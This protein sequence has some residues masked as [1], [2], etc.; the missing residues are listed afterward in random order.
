MWFLLIIGASVWLAIDE[1][2]TGGRVF[3]LAVACVSATLWAIS[4]RMNIQQQHPAGRESRAVRRSRRRL[5]Q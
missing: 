5:E 4:W 1:E 3:L 2:S